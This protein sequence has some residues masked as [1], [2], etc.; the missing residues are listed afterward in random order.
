[1]INFIF[2]TDFLI[3]SL[4]VNPICRNFALVGMGGGG[5][6][7]LLQHLPYIKVLGVFDPYRPTLIK[8][9]TKFSSYI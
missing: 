2:L 6:G 8:K 1:M 4:I 9:K 7:E 5:G 3:S